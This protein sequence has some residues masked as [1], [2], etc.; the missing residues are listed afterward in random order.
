MD[1]L[2]SVIPL[3]PW[4]VT[5][6]PGTGTL[7]TRIMVGTVLTQTDRCP[8]ALQLVKK[9]SG[10]AGE[11]G[12]MRRAS[13]NLHRLRSDVGTEWWSGGMLHFR[14]ATHS[15]AKPR[16]N[17][18][19]LQ[20]CAQRQGPPLKFGLSPLEAS[21]NSD[22]RNCVGR[23]GKRRCLSRIRSAPSGSSSLFILSTLCLEI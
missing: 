5:P 9:S 11:E 8:A 19:S 2:R 20:F 18:V 22:R 17:D 1:C 15:H 10:V 3:S 4:T 7:A 16:A 23:L 21:C 14:T 12:G 13:A 6:G